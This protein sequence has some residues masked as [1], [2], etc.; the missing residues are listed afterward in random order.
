MSYFYSSYDFSESI[1]N[2]YEIRIMN[3]S[4]FYCGQCGEYCSELNVECTSFFYGCR[5][6]RYIGDQKNI[7]NRFETLNHYYKGLIH[8]TFSSMS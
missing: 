6:L 5:C 1:L 2:Q 3:N 7:A 4:W 8:F